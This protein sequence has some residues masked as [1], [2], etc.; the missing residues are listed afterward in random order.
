MSPF[1]G[2]V[3]RCVANTLINVLLGRDWTKV[4]AL[5]DDCFPILY[6]MGTTFG[7]PHF[8]ASLPLTLLQH[9]CTKFVLFLDSHLPITVH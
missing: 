1:G 9:G 5:I 6:V 3:Y 7:A 4:V 8:Y 2:L